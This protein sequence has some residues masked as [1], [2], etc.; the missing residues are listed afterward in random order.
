MQVATRGILLL[1]GLGG[2]VASPLAMAQQ[3]LDEII[4]TSERREAS[5]QE[6]PVA[7]TALSMDQL[8]KLQVNEALDLQRYVPSLNMF[9]NITSPTNLSPSMRGGLQQDASLVTAESPFGIYVDDIYVGRLNGNNIRLSD[10]ERVEVLRG[11]QGTLYGRNTG[12]GAIRFISRTPGEDFWFN[13][14]A[15][16][17]NDEQIV[18]RASIGGPL[19]E[20]FAASLSG[21]WNE[22][23]EQYTNLAEN[24]DVDNQENLSVRGKLRWMA[25]D[26]FDAVLS[27]SYSDSENDS[28]QLIKATT[29][30]VPPNCAAIDPINGCTNGQSTQFSTSDLFFPN[31]ERNTNTPFGPRSPEPIK[32]QP[33]GETEQWIAGLTLTWD[34]ND[35]MTFRSIT[36]YVGMEDFFSTDF[37]GNTG[38][39]AEGFGALGA[40]DIDTDQ[41]SQEFQL[42]GSLLDDRLDYILGFFYLNEDNEQQFGWNLPNFPALAPTGALSQSFIETETDSYAVFGEVKYKITDALTGTVGLRYTDDEK[43]FDFDFRGAFAGFVPQIISINESW[44]EWTPRFGLDYVFEDLGWVDN[45]LVYGDVSKGYKGGGYSAIALFSTDAV[46]VYDPETNWT[47]EAGVKID[48]FGGKL[49][50][51]FAYFFS[52]IEDIQQNATVGGSGQTEFPVENAGDVEIQGLEWEITW[53]PFEGLN[54]FTSG[55]FMSGEYTDADPCCAAFA[56]LETY[57]VTANTPQTPDY[58]FSIGG[59]YTLELPGEFFDDMRFGVDYYEIDNYLTAATNDFYNDGWDQWNG[60][61]EVNFLEAWNL[62]FT[63]KNFT[64]ETNVTSGSRALGG[65]ILLPPEMYLLELTYTLQR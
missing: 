57:G 65:F 13:A 22:K 35:N 17:G 45:M 39:P 8:E 30:G 24:E 34:I 53:L 49:R 56:A 28:L 11:P 6:V 20:S 23:D 1:V 21:Q 54:L 58:M 27:V 12:Y 31:G 44:D 38:D 42:L 7:V 25:S 5:L 36:G 61:A 15:G 41:Y 62:R 16:A 64:D 60:F 32:S 50:T 47:Y 48:W 63:A 52:D 40:S 2:L 18:A 26:N 55:T 33:T 4:V 14:T 9:N 29:P 19:G 59:D 10:I 3:V 46:G 37:S 43:D 51:N